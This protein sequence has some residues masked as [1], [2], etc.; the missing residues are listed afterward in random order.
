MSKLPVENTWAARVAQ[1]RGRRNAVC[2]APVDIKVLPHLA[3]VFVQ[4]KLF[5]GCVCVFLCNASQRTIR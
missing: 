1:K 2:G 4:L 5:L 3:D